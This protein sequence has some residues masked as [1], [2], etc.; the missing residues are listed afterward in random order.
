MCLSRAEGEIIKNLDADDMLTPGALAREIRALLN[1]PDIGWT[2][3]RVLDLLPDGSTTGF[4]FDPPEGR[5]QRGVVFR[6]WRSHNYRAQVHPT[7]LS[8]RRELVIALG[9][10]MALPASCDTGLLMAADAISDG[11]FISDAGLLYRKWS[12]QAT[13]EPAH[14]DEIEWPARMRVIEQR[15][16]ALAALW[17]KRT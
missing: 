14:T 13:S 7:T 6:H 10:W 5:L 16:E 2:T 17:L 11:Y 8:I 3:A 15:A 9:G 1:Y 12:G 4:E